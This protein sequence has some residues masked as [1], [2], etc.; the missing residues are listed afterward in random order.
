MWLGWLV[1][2]LIA[3]PERLLEELAPGQACWR[4]LHSQLGPVASHIT[5]LPV[6]WGQVMVPGFGQREWSTERLRNLP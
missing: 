5:H 3:R 2:M 6:L 4:Q 1:C